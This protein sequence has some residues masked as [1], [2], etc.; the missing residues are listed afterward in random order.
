MRVKNKKAENIIELAMEKMPIDYFGYYTLVEPFAEGYYEIDKKEKAR[1]ILKKLI[2]K[3]HEELNYYKGFDISKTDRD[4]DFEIISNIERYRSLLE[5]A[6]RADDVTFYNQEKIKFNNYNK[7]FS[8]YK[9]K[10]LE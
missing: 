2:T 6:K 1:E 8:E 7:M 10:N 4:T 5:I 9:R 3:Y